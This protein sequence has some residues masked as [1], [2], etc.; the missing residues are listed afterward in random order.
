MTWRREADC[1]RR[2]PAAAPLPRIFYPCGRFYSANP[3]RQRLARAPFT[4]FLG[5]Y[6]WAAHASPGEMRAETAHRPTV[7]P[8]ETAIS[9]PRAGSL[10]G[11]PVAGATSSRPERSWP[12]APS[13]RRTPRTHGPPA[14]DTDPSGR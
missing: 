12:F 5:R 2:Y 10:D 3:V 6:G 1:H 13:P 9:V 11:R 14:R 4:A 8:L 7:A